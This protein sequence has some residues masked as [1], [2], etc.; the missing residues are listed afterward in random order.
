MDGAESIARASGS[1]LAFALRVIP[2][3]QRTDITVFYA[4]CRVIDD[5]ADD[6]DLPTS[7]KHVRLDQ[8]A[9][10]LDGAQPAHEL[11]RQTIALQ[12]RHNIPS[13]LFHAIIAGCR[14][15]IEPR[16]YSTW[17][18]LDAYIWQV[19]GAV[20]LISI[21]L[22]G[23]KDPAA[24]PYALALARGLQ[25]TNILRDIREDWENGQ[26]V[27]LPTEDLKKFGLSP[28][29]MA[30]PQ[31]P[32]FLQL[33]NFEAARADGFFQEADGLLPAADRRALLPAH[34]MGAIYRRILQKMKADGFKV[35][36]KRYRLPRIT[37]A[38][39]LARHLLFRRLGFE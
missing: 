35:A 34:I 1:N 39:M 30:H 33:M 6:P 4:F 19:A 25:L 18:E 3:K 14:S 16:R 20:G 7:E 15:D 21:R 29:A 38:A 27:Y 26:R 36:E 9:A 28:E 22:F 13:K 5:I 23:C 12:K 31:G 24:E 10:A 37:M 8:W 17:E 2:K 32:E 11:Q